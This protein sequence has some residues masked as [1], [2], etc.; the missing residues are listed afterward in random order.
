MATLAV[1]RSN[2][3]RII[4]VS[5][6]DTDDLAAIDF[7]ANE[8]VR[9]VLVAT[10][11]KIKG[12]SGTL[13]GVGFTAAD[14]AGDYTMPATW[15]AID[16]ISSVDGAMYRVDPDE[17]RSKRLAGATSSPASAYA[18][19]GE[20]LVMFSPT[21]AASDSHTYYY[22]PLPTEMSS[23]SHDPATATYGGI[24]VDG[25]DL[26]EWYMLWRLSDMDDDQSSAQGQRYRDLYL[27]GVKERR[28]SGRRRG[29][30]PLPRATVSQPGRRRGY[31]RS[32]SQDISPW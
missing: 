21:P 18:V 25:H 29:G 3:S 30:T 2:V 24:P 8:A 19:E 31:V 7:Y 28:V 5:T 15:L 12:A 6:S 32:P 14:V 16:S 17:I 4:G 9:K 26:I 1:L 27:A 22:V 11:C 20:D 13:T 23:A 10:R